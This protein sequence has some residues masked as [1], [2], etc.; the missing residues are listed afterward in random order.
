MWTIREGGN[1][2][3]LLTL[4]D[5]PD[6]QS[7]PRQLLPKVYWQNGYVDV[8]RPRAVLEHGS[9]SGRKTLGF[10][11]EEALYELDYPEDIPAVE[12]DLRRR[13]RGLRS[14]GAGAC[15]EAP[16]MTDTVR[17]GPLEV[18]AE[19]PCFVVAEIGIN[20]NGSLS[21]AKELIGAAVAAG[22]QAVKFQKRTVDVVYSP[23]ARSAA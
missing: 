12:E 8:L 10:V 19:R 13:S 14:A 5:K 7:L 2:D 18:G 4:R 9:M 22:C 6:C 16:G 21:L 17:I 1:I 23:R 20:H 3:P 11:V 15:R